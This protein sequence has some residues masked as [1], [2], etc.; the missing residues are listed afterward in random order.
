MEKDLKEREELENTHLRF[1]RK[2]GT[3][4]VIHV[5]EMAIEGELIPQTRKPGVL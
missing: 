5:L 4:E 2:R 1:R 3:M